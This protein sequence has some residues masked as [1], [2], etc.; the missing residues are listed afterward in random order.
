[1]LKKVNVTDDADS[2]TTAQWSQI[3]WTTTK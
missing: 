1:M 2:I 3:F